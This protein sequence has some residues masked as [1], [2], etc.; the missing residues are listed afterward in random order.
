MRQF[1]LFL[2]LL[3]LHSPAI[4]AQNLAPHPG[5]SGLEGRVAALNGSR[6]TLH[7][8][9]FSNPNG[10]R[11]LL[12]IPKDKLIIVPMGL[13]VALKIGDELLVVG[14]SAGDKVPLMARA[15]R[16][17]SPAPGVSTQPVTPK[18][19][20]TGAPSL[21]PAPFKVGSWTVRVEK[22]GFDYVPRV[23]LHPW[24]TQQTP[25]F[26][27]VF[28]VSGPNKQGAHASAFVVR[29]YV[30]PHGECI[31]PDSFFKE[32]VKAPQPDGDPRF[33]AWNNEVDP[34]WE[35]VDLDLDFQNPDV[36][37]PAKP[38][39]KIELENLALPQNK[40]DETPLNREFTSSFGTRY[41]LLK[42]RRA[43]DGKLEVVVSHIKPIEV[44]DLSIEGY[45]YSTDNTSGGGGIVP[46]AKRAGREGEE[47]LSLDLPAG[48]P[49]LAHLSLSMLES[50]PASQNRDAIGRVRLRF[51]VARLLRQNPPPPLKS[52][53]LRLAQGKAE[54]VQATLEPRG[55][56]W[57]DHTAWMLAFAHGSA[58]DQKRGVKWTLTNGSAQVAGHN[59]SFPI[60]FVGAEGPEP[61]FWHTDASPIGQGET[62]REITAALPPNTDRFNMKL[63]FEGRT[64]LDTP[65]ARTLS[66]AM[67]DGPV[68]TD[69]DEQSP[70]VLRKIRRFS[71]PQD[72]GKSSAWMGG[73]WPDAGL[74]LVFEV[75]PLLGDA[76]VTPYCLDAED[77]RGRPLHIGVVRGNALFQTD[78]TQSGPTNL[79]SLVVSAPAKDAKAIT[80]WLHTTERGRAKRTQTVQLKDVP[81][82]KPTK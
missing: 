17:L 54:D 28:A 71:Q 8:T 53:L 1:T 6:L 63:E 43:D 76:D 22:A 3:L 52:P 32:D 34:S 9:A 73:Q 55:I 48:Q 13:P 31:V 51:P 77:D 56:Q 35:F 12:P 18:A 39:A 72:L 11:A 20:A 65:E 26:Y 27:A 19:P 38:E 69:P 40:G 25:V 14:R 2:T 75:N 41:R 80:L 74:A 59:E 46:G 29:R 44:P 37:A 57:D 5:E 62:S 78:V 30:G 10:H 47:T 61:F 64:I 15:L 66:L 36:P 23:L 21:L 33:V 81:F 50:S 60:G 7:T 67:A 16:V 70:L 49:T 68:A 4:F 45:S 58:Q 24:T 79:Y 82:W 42:M